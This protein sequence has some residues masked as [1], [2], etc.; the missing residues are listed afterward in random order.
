[1]A[2]FTDSIAL[3][4]DADAAG[5]A[6]AERSAELLLSQGLK[7]K[8]V[9]LPGAKDPDEFIRKA[10]AEAFKKSVRSALPFLEFKIKR[11]LARHNLSE[12]EGRSRGMRE[13]AEI[14]GRENDAFTQKEYAKLAA[15]ML[16]TEPETLLA[17][18]KRQGFYRRE[19]G[20]D[21]RRVT[22]KP[23]CKV[24]EAEKRLIALSTQ[25]ITALE[26]LK[27]ELRPD[28][29][30][31][32]EARAVADILFSAKA[33]PSENLPHFVIDSLSSEAA[34]NFLTQALLSE[35]AERSEKVL[36]DCIQVIKAES[37]KGRIGLLKSELRKA[38][39]S[40]DAQKAGEIL[41]ALKNETM[42]LN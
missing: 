25:D 13:V 4:F 11:T 24:A 38:E 18:I 6:A 42:N 12:I 40:K 33:L 32:P 28:S 9:E 8:V 37:T 27:K 7:V 29:F 41:A 5:E 21:L 15:R 22:E 23:G 2:R 26:T 30:N 20:K 35:E 1:M 17:E 19:T 3:A 31:G 36:Q 39:E 34:R 14:L 16:R 10:G